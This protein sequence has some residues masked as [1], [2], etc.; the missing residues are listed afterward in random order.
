MFSGEHIKTGQMTVFSARA[1]YTA[2]RSIPSPRAREKLSIS[3]QNCFHIYISGRT[4]ENCSQ[5]GKAKR[6]GVFVTGLKI[7]KRRLQVLKNKTSV[8]TR[9]E[10]DDMQL[11]EFELV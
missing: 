1:V 7:L 8:V 9:V 10:V 11:V 6:A 5:G 3:I 2:Q 4:V